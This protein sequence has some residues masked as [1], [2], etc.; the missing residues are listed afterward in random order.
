MQ[1][2]TLP[3]ILARHDVLA[4]AKTGTGKTL[5][6]LIPAIQQLISSPHPPLSQTSVLILSP[7]RELAQQIAVVAKTLCEALGAKHAVQCVVGG[8]NV[9]TDVRDLTNLR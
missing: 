5:A 4:Q 2:A 8:T 9:K 6:F 3:T 1:G 7:T